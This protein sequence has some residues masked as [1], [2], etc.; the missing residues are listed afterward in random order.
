MFS[1]IYWKT[2][3]SHIFYTL[4]LKMVMCKGLCSYSYP[5]LWKLPVSLCPTITFVF[6][7][8]NFKRK[9]IIFYF[10]TDYFFKQASYFMIRH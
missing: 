7:L 8:H 5:S 10:L 2:G 6:S 3:T 1:H 9:Q 4:S